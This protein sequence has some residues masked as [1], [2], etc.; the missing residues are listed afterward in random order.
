MS[1]PEKLSPKARYARAKFRHLTSP[2]LWFPLGILSLLVVFIWQLSVDTELVEGDTELVAEE[3]LSA[4]DLSAIAAEIDSSE[5]LKEELESNVNVT[6]NTPIIPQKAILDDY[7]DENG[8]TLTLLEK[9]QKELYSIYEKTGREENRGSLLGE[10]RN[11]NSLLNL[12]SDSEINQYSPETSNNQLS[13]PTLP[14]PPNFKAFSSRSQQES[15]NYPRTDLPATIQE[16]FD[17]SYSSESIENDR[18]QSE[19]DN[20][21]LYET[22][23][24]LRRDAAKFPI[25]NS[26]LPGSL[27]NNQNFNSQPYYIDR[28]GD[29]NNYGSPA[30][31]TP[32]NQ[33]YYSD[34]Y[35]NGS[36]KT[37]ATQL[38]V[39]SI[40][41][42]VPNNGS[43]PKDP[44]S[45]T[46]SPY[47]QGYPQLQQNRLNN[48]A[49]YYPGNNAATGQPQPQPQPNNNRQS[50]PFRNQ[51]FGEQNNPFNNS[52]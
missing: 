37:Q 50:S 36:G 27:P 23:E 39:P 42:L 16:Y 48:G 11:N 34:I 26:T 24:D 17:S 41:P 13:N 2:L 38:N 35:G 8:K 25:D 19:N 22:Q 29:Y 51:N 40:A 28:S 3:E 52:R 14:Q 30:T 5:F 7:I 44:Y 10:N 31:E 4:E 18:R 12:G 1:N 32:A 15:S 20:S 47:N 43:L 46:G 45:R 33:P 9:T 21:Q 6:T 49:N